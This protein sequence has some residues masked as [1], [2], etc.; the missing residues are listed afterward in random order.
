M[1]DIERERM[2]HTKY[3]DVDELLGNAERETGCHDWGEDDIRVP[4][5]VLID[6]MNKEVQF[7][8][9]GLERVR[10][11][12]HSHLTARLRL[13]NDR[14]LYPGITQQSILSPIFITGAQ[15]TGTSYLNS[16]LM[17][18]P[19]NVGII[20]WQVSAPSPPVNHPNF[21]HSPQVAAGS[22][23]VSAGGW[24]EPYIRDK[25][26]WSHL[27]SEEDTWVQEY[28]FVSGAFPVYWGVPSYAKYLATVDS[29]PGYR[30]LKKFFQALLFGLGPKQMVS[31]S[32]LHISMLGDLFK[33]FPD[34]RLVVNHRDPIKSFPS[35]MSL[36][37][38]I[39]RMFGCSFPV[40]RPFAR[41]MME[42]IASGCEDM[43]RRR[44][45]PNVDRFCVD[46]NYLELEQSP[47]EQ[48]QKIYDRFGMVLADGVRQP[49]TKYIAENR[50]G[51]FG[52]HQYRLEDSG[53]TKD[54]I[55]TRFR[56][57]TDH[58]KVPLEG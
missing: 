37:A 38:A 25:H 36:V 24:L 54:E 9:A 43:I 55:R 7:D 12:I 53:L 6:S 26:D 32:P 16:L 20:N 17:S 41:L 3:F 11:Y 50:K 44:Q 52:K 49:M 1:A 57:Y 13:I 35:L 8:G 23:R 19:G 28:S 47:I 39:R 45:D 22:H 30:M 31:K 14:R 27:G 10:L 2:A 42:G 51:K 46:V 21:D 34:A 4:L 40:D 18:D 33:V 5:G 48:V 15:R 56:F 29:G 58:Y